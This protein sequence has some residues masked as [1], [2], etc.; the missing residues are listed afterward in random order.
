MALI[1]ASLPS[2]TG[3]C[4][5][6]CWQSGVSLSGNMPSPQRIL[7][8]NVVSIAFKAATAIC[9]LVCPPP[10]LSVMEHERS[11]E[12]NMFGA[13]AVMLKPSAPQLVSSTQ[14]LVAVSQVFP[15]SQS[16]FTS[17]VPSEMQ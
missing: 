7:P 4:G 13:T 10:P 3:N 11:S 5:A 17:Q 1:P 9:H 12:M 16:A 6:D 2:P 14:V 8:L 15:A